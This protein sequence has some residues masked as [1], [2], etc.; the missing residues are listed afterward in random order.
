MAMQF[1]IFCLSDM[2]WDSKEVL[3][4][5]SMSLDL[6]IMPMNKSTRYSAG[7]KVT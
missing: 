6:W 2:H 7:A 1:L 4:A 5:C 3:K